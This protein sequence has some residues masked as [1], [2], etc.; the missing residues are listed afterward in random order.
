MLGCLQDASEL[1]E[2]WAS[3]SALFAEGDVHRI[4]TALGTLRRSVSLVGH[5][6]EF[7]GSTQRLAVR[8]LLSLGQIKMHVADHTWPDQ[9]SP[10]D[11][12]MHDPPPVF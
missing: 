12:A 3:V 6:P 8:L 10:H 7:Q 9:A 1:S 2:L 11:L 4:A 5:V